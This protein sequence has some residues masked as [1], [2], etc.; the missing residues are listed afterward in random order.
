MRIIYP[1]FKEDGKCVFLMHIVLNVCP[2]LNDDRFS[3]SPLSFFTRDSI[4]L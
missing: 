1:P 3:F 4:M 2:T